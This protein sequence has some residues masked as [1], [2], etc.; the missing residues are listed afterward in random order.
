MGATEGFPLRLVAKLA[1]RM[2]DGAPLS[3][4]EIGALRALQAVLLSEVTRLF[5]ATYSTKMRGGYLRFQ[6]QY[7]RRL[8]I[9][10]WR[11]VPDLLRAEL[12]EAATQRDI[13]ACNRA[14]FRLYGLTRE[15]QSALGGNGAI[16]GQRGVK[17]HLPQG[18]SR[19]Y[20]GSVRLIA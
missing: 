16:D 4:K 17:T 13:A 9:P 1:D 18:G 2:P 20:C 10:E 15:E 11:N 12:I 5:M 6:A 7:L 8:R 14:T 19:S 3:D